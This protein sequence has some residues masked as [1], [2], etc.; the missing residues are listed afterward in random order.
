MEQTICVI[1]DDE[2]YQMIMSKIICRTGLFREKQTYCSA[3]EAL[4]DFKDP[5]RILPTVIF[6]DIN[7]PRIDGWNF[8]E[9]MREIRPDFALETRIYIVTSSIANS[10]IEKAGFYNEIEG[11]ISKPV[12]IEKIQEIAKANGIKRI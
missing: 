6:L 7:M 3:S 12:S 8:I 1:D 5:D 4:Q 9:Q 10:D 2:I 11:F